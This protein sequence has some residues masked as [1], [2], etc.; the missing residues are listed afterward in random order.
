MLLQTTSQEGDYGLMQIDTQ[1]HMEE[2]QVL[3]C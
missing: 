1:I 3:Y 2:S